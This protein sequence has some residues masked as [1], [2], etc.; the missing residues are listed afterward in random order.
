[1]RVHLPFSPLPARVLVLQAPTSR[2]GERE[3]MGHTCLGWTCAP[4]AF[5]VSL[6]PWLSLDCPS[7]SQALSHLQSGWYEGFS[8]PACYLTLQS[9]RRE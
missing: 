1:M 6:H 3:G 9:R 7:L 4:L 8:L 5:V 2:G